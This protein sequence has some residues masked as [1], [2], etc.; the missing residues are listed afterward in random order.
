[1]TLRAFLSIGWLVWSAAL[2]GAETV[3]SFE[4]RGVIRELRPQ[5]QEMVIK[6]EAIPDYM[7]AMVM[8]FTVRDAK[9][10]EGVQAGDSVTFKLRVTEKE[11][12]L[13]D[14]KIIA[15]ASNPVVAKAVLPEVKVGALLSLA[16]IQLVDQSGR[17]F[18][19]DETRGKAVALTF[20]FTRCPFPKMC[21]LLAQK[22][23]TTQKLLK[24]RGAMET[25]LLSV[26]ID[27]EHDRPEVLLRYAQHH[28]AD[29]AIWRFATGDIKTI[30]QLALLCG[31][32]FW[33]EKGLVNHELRTLVLT[34]EGRVQRVFTGSGWSAQ[35]LV[36]ELSQ[37]SKL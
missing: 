10:F 30:T 35:E 19:L 14:L 24:A 8:P 3:Q 33:E 32:N 2:S 4:V 37:T 22:F 11:D 20:I 36:S 15:R 5:E 18:D 26:S 31:V 13:E 34:P 29:T 6:H 23:A 25:L 1:M 7:E 16:G 17:P 9:L 21:P 12:W 28:K 27:P